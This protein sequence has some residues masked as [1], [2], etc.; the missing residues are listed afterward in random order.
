M[1]SGLTLEDAKAGS[2][3]KTENCNHV[4]ACL[5]T[6]W[7]LMLTVGLC[8]PWRISL[9]NYLWPICVIASTSLHAGAAF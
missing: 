9:N 8:L 5:L 3:L 6:G 2:V 1:L 4:K 7:R